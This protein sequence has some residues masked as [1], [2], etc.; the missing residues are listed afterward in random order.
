MDDVSLWLHPTPPDIQV[1]NTPMH[2]EDPSNITLTVQKELHV[3]DEVSKGFMDNITRNL[4]YLGE[5]QNPKIP[6][7]PNYCHLHQRIHLE[8]ECASCQDAVSN[9]LAQT[10]QPVEIIGSNEIVSSL[11]VAISVDILRNF[12]KA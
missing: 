9:V 10:N 12:E 7:L 4:E 6:F 11:D 1:C 5:G 8:L 2:Y 3:K